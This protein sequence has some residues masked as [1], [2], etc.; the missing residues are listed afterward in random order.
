MAYVPVRRI[1]TGHDSN[2]KAIIL[3]DCDAPRVT[4]M[5]GDDGPA[6]HEIWTTGAMPAMID[7]AS[8]EP[9]EDRVSLLPPTNGTRIRVI[10]APP[11][12][13]S[14]KEITADQAQ[15]MFDMI[16]APNVKT[17]YAESD[18]PHPL[19]HRTETLDYAIILEGE[20][21]LILD[22]SETVVRAGDIVIQ[23][24]TNHSWA[25]RGKTKCRAIFVMIDGKFERDL[26]SDR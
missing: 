18:A 22:D 16:N 24:G 7:R 6:F 23:R 13:A 2:G 26:T 8:G 3:E 17:R 19:M 1:V 12:T 14:D 20:M 10:D 4:E 25:N 21:T 9:H 5:G 15:M 11:E